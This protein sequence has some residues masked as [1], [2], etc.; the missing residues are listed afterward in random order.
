[1]LS[2]KISKY[3]KFVRVDFFE[4]NGEMYLG[5]ITFIPMSGIGKYMPESYDLIEGDLLKL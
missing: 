4:V 3:F 1:M 2:N 5:E